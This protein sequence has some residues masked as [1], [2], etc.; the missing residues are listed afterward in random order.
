M[1]QHKVAVDDAKLSQYAAGTHRKSRREKE[2]EAAEAKKREEQVNAAKAYADF[3]DAFEGGDVGRKSGNQFVKAES[4]SKYTPALKGFSDE[5]STK[6][7]VSILP[8]FVCFWG[9]T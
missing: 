6:F 3:I 5:K 7:E 9:L 4:G 1:N 2:Q 8:L